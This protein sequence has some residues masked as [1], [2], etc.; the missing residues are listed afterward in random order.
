MNTNLLFLFLLSCPIIGQTFSTPSTT[1]LSPRAGPEG[2]TPT[3][4]KIKQLAF[5]YSMLFDTFD[6]RDQFLNPQKDI[7]SHL[8]L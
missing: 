7:K 8:L 3:T 1:P 5:V 4:G 6:P 2:A